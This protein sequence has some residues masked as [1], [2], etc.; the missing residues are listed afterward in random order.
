M[1]ISIKNKNFI[2]KNTQLNQFL[3]YLKKEDVDV[4]MIRVIERKIFLSNKHYKVACLSSIGILPSFRGKGYSKIL[5]NKTNLYLKNFFDIS[6]LIARK[7]LDFFYSKFNFIGNSEFYLIKFYLG[8]N[9]YKNFFK[10]KSSKINNQ[11][12]HTYNQTNKNKN[13]FFKRS[14]FDWLVIEKKIREN[15]LLVK[16]FYH[17][18]LYL[19]FA[20]FKKNTI[21]EYGFKA[22]KLSYFVKCLKSNF[23]GKVVIRN[24]DISLLN[25]IKKNHQITINKRFCE[26]GGHM[27]NW[28]NQKEL[29][30]I[31][32]NINFLDEF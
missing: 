2:W 3:I 19:G 29:K 8:K 23:K 17:K 16:K 31:K 28:F 18:K 7:K 10:I 9:E 25:Q 1:K 22:K 27:I 6:L 21:Y 13:G 14:K 5:M 12:I 11:I 32:Y 15:N 24:P 26:Y 30:N 20:I 4:G